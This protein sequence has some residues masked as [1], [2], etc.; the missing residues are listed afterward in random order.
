MSGIM[1]AQ[2]NEQ[3]NE[4]SIQA[5]PQLSIAVY[6]VSVVSFLR[7]YNN[8]SPMHNYPNTY[9]LTNTHPDIYACTGRRAAF[10]RCQDGIKM[11]PRCVKMCQDGASWTHLGKSQEPP[12]WTH[13]DM[14]LDMHVRG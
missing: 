13:L 6:S 10:W 4:L 7:V 12:F 2:V 8:L 3:V 14:H 9:K 5:S 11:V 1:N